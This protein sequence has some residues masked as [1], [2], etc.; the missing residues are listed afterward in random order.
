MRLCLSK[1]SLTVFPILVST[2]RS[3]SLRLP[4]LPTVSVLRLRLLSCHLQATLLVLSSLARLTPFYLC[5]FRQDQL[6]EAAETPQG[7]QM[8]HGTFTK[9]HPFL[10]SCSFRHYL[11]ALV[12]PT[13]SFLLSPYLTHGKLAVRRSG[14]QRIGN[15]LML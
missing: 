12:S 14:S 7:H 11:Y 10:S 1:L 2:H 5:S 6:T 9:Q 3:L 13:T 4:H 8:F 15:A